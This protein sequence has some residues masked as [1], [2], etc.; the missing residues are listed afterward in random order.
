MIVLLPMGEGTV[1]HGDRKLQLELGL[2]LALEFGVKVR[3][4]R[5]MKVRA[6]ALLISSILY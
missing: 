1:S 6:A 2:R 3:T 5:T 4:M